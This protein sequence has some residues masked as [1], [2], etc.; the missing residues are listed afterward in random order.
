MRKIILDTNF[1]I[2][3]YKFKIDLKQELSKLDLEPYTVHVIDKTIDELTR[4]SIKNVNARIALHFANKFKIIKTEGSYV[5]DI[6]AE[7]DD[8]DTI[9]A[10]D[11]YELKKRLKCKKLVIKSKSHL[12]LVN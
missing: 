4:L 10:T 2:D 5:D 9:I 1:L 6:L 12:M 7:F 11:D 8:K 3:L